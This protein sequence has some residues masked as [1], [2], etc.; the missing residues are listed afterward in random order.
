MV[1]VKQKR[2]TKQLKRYTKPAGKGAFAK[3]LT[4]A[5]E[6]VLRNRGRQYRDGGVEY[7]LVQFPHWATFSEEFPKGVV[8]EREELY[9]TRKIN[10]VKLVDW[11][12]KNGHSPYDSGM[13]VKQTKH[14]MRLEKQIERMFETKEN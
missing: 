6:I 10:A 2:A 12:Y 13:L 7:I 11:L 3:M 4:A 5:S 8:V 9:N 1:G 14:Y